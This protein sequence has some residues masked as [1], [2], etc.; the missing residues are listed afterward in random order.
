MTESSTR[1][2]LHLEKNQDSQPHGLNTIEHNCSRLIPSIYPKFVKI[3]EILGGEENLRENIIFVH[4]LKDG[5]FRN[6]FGKTFKLTFSLNK[7]SQINFSRVQQT[8]K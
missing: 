1:N 2:E 6:V 3:L 5:I 4:L 7:K 8:R